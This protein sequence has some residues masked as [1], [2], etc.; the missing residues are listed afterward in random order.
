M[1]NELAEIKGLLE[2]LEAKLDRLQDVEAIQRLIVT[3]ARG[4]DRGNDP[5]I[6]GP[7]F[8]EDGTWECKGFGKYHGREKLAKG[9]HGIAG[10][11]IWWSLHY[12][13]SPL[14]DIALDRRHIRLRVR[15]TGRALAVPVHGIE[16]EHGE[17]LRRRLGKGQIPGRQP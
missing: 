4:C 17:S 3:Y 15:K 1:S 11:K 2:K 10:E 14:I 6:I 13:I 12:M 8:A 9:L 5:E 16:A 7:C